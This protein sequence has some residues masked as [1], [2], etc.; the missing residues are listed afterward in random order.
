M[1]G[2]TKQNKKTAKNVNIK[3]GGGWLET[4]SD[5][6]LCHSNHRMVGVKES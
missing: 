1:P 5:A 4:P 2:K 3:K 6:N